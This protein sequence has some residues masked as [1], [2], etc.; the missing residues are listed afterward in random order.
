MLHLHGGYDV[1]LKTDGDLAPTLIGVGEASA[2]PGFCASHDSETF[3][4]IE[5]REFTASPEQVFLLC[6]R[7]LCRELYAY[8]IKSRLSLTHLDK[9]MR[10]EGQQLIQAV[11]ASQSLRVRRGLSE[12]ESLKDRYDAALLSKSYSELQYL[13]IELERPSDILMSTMFAPYSDFSGNP[14][15]SS[16]ELSRAYEHCVLL[17]L[18]DSSRGWFVIAWLGNSAAG[19]ALARSLD[20][21]QD[22]DVPDVLTRLAFSDFE[23]VYFR[24]SWWRGLPSHSTDFLRRLRWNP[25]DPSGPRRSDYLVHGETNLATWGVHSRR[26]NLK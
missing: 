17:L 7:A 18:T 16:A 6:Y 26:N 9:G 8:R 13:A 10:L 3:A 19:S 15:R 1:F 22:G 24:P 12:L 4:P 23:N 11:A 20:L 25:Q 5:T 2:F 21:V 14:I